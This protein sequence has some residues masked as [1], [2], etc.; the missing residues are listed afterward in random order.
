MRPTLIELL[1]PIN[2]KTI[3]L[4]FLFASSSAFAQKQ[5]VE[6]YMFNKDWKAAKDIASAAYIMHSTS[7]GDSLFVNRIFNGTGS[8]LSQ[9]SFK[10]ASQ[11]ITHGQ[12]AWYDDQGRIDSSGYVDNKRK[13]GSWAYYDDTLGIYLLVY[14][15]K[16]KEVER[17][18]YVNKI[19]KTAAGEKTFEQEKQERDSIKKEK[20]KE[21]TD[22]KEAKFTGG[23]PGLKKYLEKNI[24]PP[25]NLIKTGTVKSQFVI[26]KVGKIENLLI[27]RSLQLSADVEALRVLSEMPAWTPAY[28]NGKN[29]IYQC[30]QSLTFQVN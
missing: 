30:I 6:Y 14:Y 23:L 19:I 26:N 9:E 7:I 8:L 13:S 22:E 17:R 18:D 28:Q 21:P 4:L 1:S 29:V 16:G 2:M 11:T 25:N 10:D 3:F 15:E 20:T 24:E 12:F 27:L 5:K